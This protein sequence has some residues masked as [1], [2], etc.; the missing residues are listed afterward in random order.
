MKTRSPLAILRRAYKMTQR[1]LANR[2]NVSVRSISRWERGHCIPR[3]L[4][5]LRLCSIFECSEDQFGWDKEESADVPS[6]VDQPILD[7]TLPSPPLLFGRREEL[8]MLTSW[9]QKAI[10]SG[11]R[12]HIVITGSEGI[13]KTALVSQALSSCRKAHLRPFLAGMLSANLDKES[14]EEI[15]TRWATLFGDAE[16]LYDQSLEHKQRLLRF[17][18]GRQRM[19][20]VLDGLEQM[21][22][23]HF[24]E[25]MC[26]SGC[27]YLITTRSPQLAEQIAPQTMLSLGT[28]P[29]RDVLAWIR[30]QAPHAE[31][32]LGGM[33]DDLLCQTQHH[34]RAVQQIAE[35][36]SQMKSSA[37]LR[38]W[39]QQ[40][41]EVYQAFSRLPSSQVHAM[42][43]SLAKVSSSP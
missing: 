5:R 39:D 18:I 24:F 29:Q 26:G 8:G 16:L 27:T 38:Q 33:L 13:G 30:S 6:A 12:P 25:N 15:L 14:K 22:D 9:C 3:P 32:M 19:I 23:L 11:V 42:N 20:I 7:P 4:E 41:R 17:A 21:D 10:I 35:R 2:L 40:F 37:S 28:L 31:K 1:K 36:F 43:A 34:P